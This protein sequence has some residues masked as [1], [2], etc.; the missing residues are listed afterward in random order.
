M[1]N[2]LFELFGRIAVDASDAEKGIDSTVGR[3]QDAENKLSKTFKRIGATIAT[4][5]AVDKLVEFGKACTQTFAE[6]AAEESA[7]AQIM[8]DYAET[9]QKKLDKVAENTGVASTR[10]TSHMTSLT[11]KFKGLGYDVDDATTLASDGLQLA[12]D[13]AAFWDKSLDESMSHLNSFL[14]GSYEGGEAIGLFANDTQMAA[15]AIEKGIVKDTK[16]WAALDEATKQATRLDFA[17]AMYEQSGATGQA[18][19]ESG[20]YANVLANL[21]NAWE[22]FKATVGKPLLEKFVLPA[23]QKLLDIM[24]DITEAVQGG[25][26]W[27][28][29]KFDVVASYFTDVFTEDGLNLEALPAALGNMFRDMVRNLPNM[30]R[31]L[32]GV[33]GN[34]WSDTVWPMIQEI[35]KVVF[36]IDV[37]NWEEVFGWL[38]DNGEA[39]ATAAGAVALAFSFGKHPLATALTAIGGAFVA[40]NT[41]WGKFEENYPELVDFFEDLTG[42]EFDDAA[43]FLTGLQDEL[44]GIVEWMDTHAADLSLLLALLG[45]LAMRSGHYGV[46]VGLLIASDYYVAKAANESIGEPM[47]SSLYAPGLSEMTQ[48]ENGMIGTEEL[49]DAGGGMYVPKSVAEQMDDEYVPEDVYRAVFGFSSQAT[50]VMHQT[51]SGTW[52]GGGGSRF[53]ESLQ[54]KFEKL[55]EEIGDPADSEGV[56]SVPWNK[57]D[58]SIPD[59]EPKNNDIDESDSPFVRVGNSDIG[60]LIATMQSYMSTYNPDTIAA[61]VEAGMSAAKIEATV[62]T[63]N[64]ILNGK[65]VGRQLVP[66]I[67]IRL[68]TKMAGLRRG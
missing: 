68:G 1:S 25:L 3:A 56:Y 50:S 42:I 7:F 64:V 6:I 30:L 62:T 17:K 39:L 34:V 9:A 32:G 10:M 31:S 4:A 29:E 20:E 57:I 15:Y 48:S 16:A 44:N 28:L 61:A 2:A 26:D 55:I 59:P 33:L 35:G 54:E 12:A 18:A 19:K 47:E 8:G 46:G 27:L 58:L 63:G 66:D 5:F 21:R 40:L 67:D 43:G 14:N 60:T 22:R 53:G 24:P 51:A 41:D 36:D 65:Q 52:K 49:V 23:M 13:A 38:K 45:G 37:P 11:A